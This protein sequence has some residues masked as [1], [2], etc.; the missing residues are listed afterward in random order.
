MVSVAKTHRCKCG[1]LR[2]K[3]DVVEAARL[4]AESSKYREALQKIA[5]MPD[6]QHRD[7]DMEELACEALTVSTRQ[8]D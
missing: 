8:N 3:C 2:H 7:M 1:G 5:N 4:L 6:E